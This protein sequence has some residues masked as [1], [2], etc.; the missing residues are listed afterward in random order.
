MIIFEIKIQSNCILIAN[1][2]NAHKLALKFVGYMFYGYIGSI[3][4]KQEGHVASK[5]FHSSSFPGG[6]FG[7][8][9]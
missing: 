3:H 7:R 5:K 1:Y 9:A 8:P 4:I 2:V 6:N